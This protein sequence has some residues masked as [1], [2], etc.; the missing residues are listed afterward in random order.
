M[1][2]PT[3]YNDILLHVVSVSPPNIATSIMATCRDLYHEGAKLVLQHPIILDGPEEKA[4]SLMRFIQAED[5]SRCF[6]VRRFLVEIDPMPKSIATSLI[7][8]LFRMTSLEHLTIGAENMME[9]FPALLPAFAAIRSLKSLSLIG[10]GK[11]SIRFLETLQSKLV[12][13]N[14]YFT[15]EG[16]SRNLSLSGNTHPIF[17]LERSASTLEQL[18]CVSWFDKIPERHFMRSHTTYPKMRS[19]TLTH[20][21]VTSPIPYIRAF[22][23]LEFLVVNSDSSDEPSGPLNLSQFQRSLNIIFQDPSDAVVWKWHQLGSFTGRLID[24]WNLGILCPIRHLTLD[25]APDAR[26]PDALTDVL[27]SASPQLLVLNFRGSPFK[28]VLS[29][30]FLSALRT[31]GAAQIRRLVVMIDMMAEDREVDVA[32]AMVSSSP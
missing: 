27:E 26:P 3:L 16:S 8:I 18:T 2:S 20:C 12:S 19:L 11:H 21:V 1:S 4:L 13:A 24:L 28:D 7:S 14:L 30:D 22:P 31:K 17:M 9:S 6:Y 5:L 23:N 25:D 10:I 32:K 15:T 29:S